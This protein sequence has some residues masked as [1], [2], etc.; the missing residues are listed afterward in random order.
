MKTGQ[1]LYNYAKS[2]IP[3]GTQILSKRPELFLPGNWPAY[4]SKAKDITVWDLD[5]E[6]YTDTTHN[7]LGAS[8]LGYADDDVNNAIMDAVIS[9]SMTTLN[10]P[11]EIELAELLIEH[12][13][14][15]K[16]VRYARTG[17]EACSIAIRIARAA[18][19][20]DI[21]LFCGYH[22][23][24][25]WY[26]SSNLSSDKNLDGQL[27]PGL[28]PLG[29]PRNLE[30]TAHPF[31]YNNLESFISLVEKFKGKIAAVIMEPMRNFG[32]DGDF[33]TKIRKITQANEIVLIF[34][35]VTSGFR[36]CPGGIHKVLG[37]E[38]DLAVFGKAIANGTPMAAIIGRK[39]IMEAAQ[40]SFISSAFWSEKIGFKAALA[41]IN[42][43]IKYS[44][45]DSLIDTGNKIQQLW[46]NNASSAGLS[47]TIT[48]IP[49]L[50]F[51]KFDYE[52]SDA[53]MTLF[54]QEMLKLK[55]LASGSFYVLWPHRNQ[56]FLVDYNAAIE[57]VFPKLMRAIKSGDILELLEGPVK[58]SNFKRL[59]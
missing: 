47:I 48:G 46:K 6:K 12:H 50:S 21:I 25:D 29:V 55:Y 3:G 39:N 5:G 52:E 33:L 24:H 45:Y 56:E 15:A 36:M 19:S 32:P 2:I 22:G 14:W 42:K 11:E 23:W 49:P 37:V 7:G 53:I 8:I 26:I 30:N 40:E 9:G 27:L 16:M 4:Y 51:L 41:T 10:C 34:D 35:E 43:C 44:V 31:F 1:K 20:K 28:S 59:T 13:P 58:H 18:T 38:P 57:K 54:T 17:G